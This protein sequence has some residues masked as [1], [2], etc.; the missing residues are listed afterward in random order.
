[1]NTSVMRAVRAGASCLA[2]TFA[3]PAV[4]F[5][6]DS[7]RLSALQR[8][9]LRLDPR[10]RQLDLQARATELRLRNI[11]A[12]NRPALSVD[13]QAQYQST[14]TRLPITL[15]NV[16]VPTPP[17]DTY[18]ARIGAQQTLFDPTRDA[19]RAVE[20]AQLAESQAQTRATIFALRQEINDAF[21]AAAVMQERI[22]IIDAAVTDLTARLRETVARFREGTALPGDTAAIAA[23][24]L[25]RE[26]DRIQLRG[27]RTAA[28]ARLSE[29]V[30]R[31]VRDAE[32]L[33]VEDYGATVA[34]T[35][36]AFDTLRLRPEY[37]QFAAARDRLSRA[38]DV[39]SSQERPRVSAFG[40]A[41]YGRPGLDMLSRDFQAY[42][43]AGVQVHWAP[44]TWGNASRDRQAASLQQE[45]IATNEQAFA[46]GLRRGV[47]HSLAAMARLDST[48]A[49][50]ERIIALRERI[51]SETRIRLGEGVVTAAEYVDRNTDLLTARLLRTQH[52]IEL[53][54]ARATYLTTLG[55]EVP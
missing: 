15:P 21:F 33:A 44:W 1:M 46:R 8:E 31:P 39:E 40:R 29:L 22:I 38:M 55:V 19:R 26:Q 3:L 9:A 13:G 27:D 25:Q 6:Q 20:R 17:H 7:L 53:A 34:R 5:A 52:R 51:E 54:Q 24:I 30:A 18:D 48:L 36:Q 16:S 28:L 35:M 47:Q 4:A 11:D 23:T 12:E 42:W 32:P 10:Q 37:A 14:V 45:I 2:L 50:D 49:L 41:G 43:V